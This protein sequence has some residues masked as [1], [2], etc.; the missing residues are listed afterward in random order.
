MGNSNPVFQAVTLSM[1]VSSLFCFSKISPSNQVSFASSPSNTS[2]NTSKNF[3]ESV[4]LPLD[5]KAGW[6]RRL[7]KLPSQEKDQDHGLRARSIPILQYKMVKLRFLGI[8]TGL[9]EET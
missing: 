6:L 7:K 8:T 4:R 2:L 5:G 3:P 9:N 1:L